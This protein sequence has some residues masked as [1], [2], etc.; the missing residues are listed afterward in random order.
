MRILIAVLTVTTVAL[1]AGD[2]A[3][4]RPTIVNRRSS[5]AND[6]DAI[7]V[8]QML[9]YQGKLT[10]TLGQPVPDGNYQLTFR[11][12][13]QP[14]GGS[15]IWTEGQTIQVVDGLFSALLGSVTPISSVPDGGALYLSLQIALNPE[16]APRLRIVSSA[17]AFLTARAADAD[18]LQG[19]DTTGF[20]RA[21][22][23]GS[24]TSAMIADG[25]IAAAD[26][27]QMGAASGQVMKWTGSAWAP[28]NDSISGA[29]D[30][31][32]VRVGSD[33]VLYTIHQLGIARGGSNN[34]LLG[35]ARQTHVNFGV[36]CT[37]GTSGL[38]Y[39]RCVVAG[40][41][42][43]AATNDGAAVVAGN[44]NKARGFLSFVGGG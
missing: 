37:T 19:K 4:V 18:L 39:A 30:N 42:N 8:P 44:S 9:S 12:Y 3:V 27:G 40:G 38:A 26:L 23:T 25:N 28:R 10:D 33:S 5:T 2:A 14:S 24:V 15:A 43:N 32:W 20:V 35:T 16:L 31:A 11:L 7:T 22:Q 36:G 29:G 17:Y 1:A 41:L 21:G 34:V 13:T 6:I